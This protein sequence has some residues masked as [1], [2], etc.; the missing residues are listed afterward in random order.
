MAIPLVSVLSVIV[1]I[2]LGHP[3]VINYH[4]VK[5]TDSDPLRTQAFPISLPYSGQAMLA[6]EYEFPQEI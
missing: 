3:F 5:G 2:G 4:Q 1:T 6:K